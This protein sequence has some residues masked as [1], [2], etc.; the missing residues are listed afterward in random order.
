MQ[1]DTNTAGSLHVPLSSSCLQMKS[2][3]QCVRAA[4]PAVFSMHHNFLH[5]AFTRTPRVHATAAPSPKQLQPP[6]AFVST[7]PPRS[8]HTNAPPLSGCLL[9]TPLAVS[10]SVFIS[11]FISLSCCSH[12]VSP[13]CLKLSQFVTVDVQCR[14]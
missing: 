6:A 8:S 7:S 5:V 4:P 10:P 2:M 1:S 3:K 11:R 13:E 14:K 9:P 12:C